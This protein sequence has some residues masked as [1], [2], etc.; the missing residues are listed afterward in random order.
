MRL[1]QPKS[2]V[3]IYEQFGYDVTST[4]G[5]ELIGNCVFCGKEKHFYIN[6]LNAAFSCKRCGE[7]GSW[8]YFLEKF[9]HKHKIK[10]DTLYRQLMVKRQIPLPALRNWNFAYYNN[11]YF[12]PAYDI[13]SE[14][15]D[16][17]LWKPG[18]KEHSTKGGNVGIV[19]LPELLEDT[20]APVYICEAYFTAIALDWLLKRTG[21]KGVVISTCGANTFRED[22]M[23]HFHDRDV[24]I[25]FDHDDAGYG[26]INGLKV[27]GSRKVEARLKNSAKSIKFVTWPESLKKGYDVRDFIQTHKANPYNGL[28]IFK[29][30]IG[31]HRDDGKEPL[32][33]PEKQQ[34]IENVKIT[35]II[36]LAAHTIRFNSNLRD[37]LKLSLAT[38]F[39][40]NLRGDC[41]VWLFL[42]GAPGSGKTLLLG[43]FETS[44]RCI[45]ESTLSSTALISGWGLG[46]NQ[47]DPS[48]LARINNRCLVL[49]DFTEVLSKGEGERE[50]IFGILR[51]GYDGRVSRPFGT[52]TRTYVCHFTFLA[53]VTH[54]IKAFSH[55]PLGERFLRYNITGIE[56]D[57]DILD[58]ALDMQIFREER[59]TGLQDSVANFLLK[60]HDLS[61]ERLV[62]LIPGWFKTRIKPLAKTIVNLRAAVTRF[63]RGSRMGQV[64]YKPVIERPNRIASQLLNLGLSLAIIQDKPVIDEDD[65]R[66]L[67]QVGLDTIDSYTT[68]IIK[69]MIANGGSIAKSEIRTHL[70]I[71]EMQHYVQDLDLL[72]LIE[73][74]G[75]DNIHVK[76]VIKDLWLRSGLNEL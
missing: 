68:D 72:N 32:V 8:R 61:S 49:K 21:E 22:W 58:T 24:I 31:K 13:N 3:E 53:G 17:R 37:G 73:R 7:E 15:T 56:D 75:Q 20:S 10:D 55:T 52:G 76:K 54:Q 74:N 33:D 23:Y 51:G 65:Y 30:Y 34:E 29:G 66:L 16:L 18:G 11:K 14:V 63:D 12:L 69:Y 71:K 38:A 44:K 45:W 70:K 46:R 40:V 67:C 25:V 50:D 59:S 39:S 9:Y 42:V 64:A 43:M 41:P 4:N 60:D 1:P 5:N 36:D 35:E 2:K 48:I 57:D 26:D 47:L 62:S 19:N 27:K 6:K 28:K